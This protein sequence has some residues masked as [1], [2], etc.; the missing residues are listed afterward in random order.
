MFDEPSVDDI[1]RSYSRDPFLVPF[2]ARVLLYLAIM[3]GLTLLF[4]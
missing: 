1:I 3:I 2:V 4:G